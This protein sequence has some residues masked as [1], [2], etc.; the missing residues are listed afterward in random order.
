MHKNDLVCFNKSVAYVKRCLKTGEPIQGFRPKTCA[1]LEIWRQ[2]NSDQIK[3][4][5]AEGKD[6]FHLICDSGG[7]RR[8]APR[9]KRLKFPSDGLFTVVR[10]RCRVKI[11]GG[12]KPGQTEILCTV[13]GEQGFVS[14]NL[15]EKV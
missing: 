9:T 6:T 14:R 15:L 12:V 11:G 2:Q 13:T 1:E 8:I 7:E 3:E 10:A 4:A 5:E